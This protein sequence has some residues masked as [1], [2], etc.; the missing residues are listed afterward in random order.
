MNFTGIIIGVITFLIIGLLH[1]VVIKAE[2]FF[3]TKV[4]PIFLISGLLCIASSLFL[5]S[6]AASS[7][8]SVLGFSLL[9]GIRE[10]FEQKERVEK[11]WFPR[12]E[13]KKH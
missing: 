5:A 4:W 6:V 13:K 9:W 2:Y 1:P 11:G 3:G 12:N 10:L 8:L 7:I